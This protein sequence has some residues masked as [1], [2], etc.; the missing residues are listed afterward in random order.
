MREYLLQYS[1][2]LSWAVSLLFLGKFAFDWWRCE[3]SR[4]NALLALTAIAVPAAIAAFLLPPRGG[5]DNNH[6][7][8]SLGTT[9]FTARPVVF[10]L[11]KEYSPLFTDGLA[12]LLSGFSLR[13]VLWKNRLLPVLSLFIFFA[14][15]R[16]LGAGLAAS[17]GA[18]A[19]LFLNFLSPLNASSFSTTS[20]NMFIWL[21]SLLALF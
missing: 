7:Y 4:G 16:R 19:L 8:L 14:G 5:Y 3:P 20:S 10:P 9:F 2:I 17:A 15:L 13:A 12:D 11:F 1:V 6:D 18:A 21:L